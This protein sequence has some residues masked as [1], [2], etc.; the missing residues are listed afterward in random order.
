MYG[1][2][3]PPN[4][5]A[6][7]SGE[8]PGQ[9]KY[10][11]GRDH[12]LTGALGAIAL[13][14]PPAHLHG[15]ALALAAAA[16]AGAALLPDLDEP[17][18]TASRVA[19]PPSRA[20]SWVTGRLAGGHR[21]ATHSLL[22][23]AALAGL[24]GWVGT[25]VTAEAVVVGILACLAVRGAVPGPLR[26]LAWPAGAAAGWWAYTHPLGPGVLAACVG[27][28][29]LAH[30]VGDVMTPAGVPALWPWR[31]RVAVPILA[32]TGSLAERLA[33]PVIAAVGWALI[34]WR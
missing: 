7:R 25:H 20:V 32:R 26:R 12:A 2:D 9:T 31:H 23:A 18:S 10:M 14:L 1:R 27:L 29:I 15:P 8:V 33:V 11:I 19:G 17:G 22:A 5:S 34:I 28:G 24:A 16:T 6:S 30:L 3:W 4:K 13:A 21:Q